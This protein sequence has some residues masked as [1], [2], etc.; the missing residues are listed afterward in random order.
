MRTLWPLAAA[1]PLIAG[2]SK[3]TPQNQEAGTNDAPAQRGSR[4]GLQNKGRD[5]LVNVAQAWAEAYKD[6][7]S[8]G[9]IA[10]SGG[11]SGTGISSLINGSADIANASRKIKAKEVRAAQD[12]L[13]DP[14]EHGVG[15]SGLAYATDEVKLVCVAATDGQGC[16]MPSTATALEGTYPIARPLLLYTA[17]EPTGATKTYLDWILSDTGQCI[18]ADKGYAPVRPVDCGGA[19]SSSS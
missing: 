13:I 3:N 16:L 5:T 6:V 1:A 9:A 12:K 4:S 2:C 11:G 7:G 10:V 14:K 17:G 18:I 19:G 8:S 15:Y